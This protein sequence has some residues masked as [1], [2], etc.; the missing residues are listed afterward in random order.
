MLDDGDDNFDEKLPASD[1]QMKDI[2]DVYLSSNSNDSLASQYQ[3]RK[4]CDNKI[5]TKDS[6]Q[7]IRFPAIQG[8]NNMIECKWSN[9]QMSFTT[10]GRLSDHLKVR[11]IDD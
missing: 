5:A 10:Y 2:K 1:E 4:T 8:P 6:S 3:D 9:C 7:K 11:I